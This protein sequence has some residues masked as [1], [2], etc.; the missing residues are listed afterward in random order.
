MKTDSALTCS[1]R[2]FLSLLPN[3]ASVGDPASKRKPWTW[4]GAEHGRGEVPH[5][6]GMGPKS[7]ASALARASPARARIRS[8]GRVSSASHLRSRIQAQTPDLGR[9]RTWPGGG[10]PGRGYGTQVARG[11]LGERKVG[12][13]HGVRGNEQHTTRMPVIL[14][15]VSRPGL[16]IVRL[17]RAAET[18][19]K[20]FRNGPERPS[21]PRR[22]SLLRHPGLAQTGEISVFAQGLDLW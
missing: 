13:L 6:G 2:E 21:R 15:Q 11:S 5:A 16:G 19:P 1:R 14:Q 4:A 10:P 18:C 3:T 7:P 20:P 17:S 9:R 12:F 22:A 8:P